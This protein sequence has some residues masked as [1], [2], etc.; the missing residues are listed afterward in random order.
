MRAL[1]LPPGTEQVQLKAEILLSSEGTVHTEHDL[2]IGFRPLP[3]DFP[4]QLPGHGVTALPSLEDSVMPEG[5]IQILD[6]GPSLEQTS[7]G[8]CGD[9]LET[10]LIVTCQVCGTKVHKE[11]WEYIGGCTTYA[12]EGRPDDPG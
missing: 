1:A 11:C 8:V 12:C 7:C 6:T 9:Q 2:A 5:A 10:D 4:N 3:E